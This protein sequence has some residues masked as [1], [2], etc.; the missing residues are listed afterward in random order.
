MIY[1]QKSGNGYMA[2]LIRLRVDRGSRLLGSVK[3]EKGAEK[4]NH[5]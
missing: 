1:A 3:I 2:K 4:G 5:I